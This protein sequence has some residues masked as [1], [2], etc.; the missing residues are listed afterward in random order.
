[1][2]VAGEGGSDMYHVITELWNAG[3]KTFSSHSS[4]MDELREQVTMSFLLYFFHVS[5]HL[6]ELICN[7]GHFR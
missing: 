4:R 3:I 5:D 2:L 1:M 7:L 6:I